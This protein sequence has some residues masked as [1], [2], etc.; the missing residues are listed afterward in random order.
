MQSDIQIVVA[1]Q[2]KGLTDDPNFDIS[3]WPSVDEGALVPEMAECFSKRKRAVILYLEG[4]SD[5]L[6]FEETGIGRKQ[7]YRL[8][9]ERCIQTHPDGRVYGWRGL[10]KH[11]RINAPHRK[12]KITVNNWG[13]G[14]VGALKSTMENFPELRVKFEKRVLSAASETTLSEV[15]RPRKAN[16]KWLIDKFREEGLEV[17]GEWPFNTARLGYGSIRKYIDSILMGNP[18]LAAKAIG[19][20]DLVK[21]LAASD[22]TNRPNLIAFD[23]VEVDAHKLDGRFCVMIPQLDGDYEPKIVHRLWVVVILEVVSRAVLGYQFSMGKEVNKE[24]VLKAIKSALTKWSPR[25]VTF[26]ECSYH[27]GAGFPSS[28]NVR[29]LGACW[30]EFSVDGALANTCNSVADQIA[31]VV[32]AK[33]LDPDNSYSVRRTKDDRPFIETFFRTV[34]KNGLQRLNNTTGGKPSD[35]NGY[36]PVKIALTSQFQIEYAEDLIDTLIANYNVAPHGMLGSRSPLAY[37]DFITSNNKVPIR[38]ADPGEIQNLLNTRKLVTLKG[39]FSTGRRPYVNFFGATYSADW[40]DNQQQLVGQKL[41][42]NNF[43]EDDARLIRISN[44]D[45]VILGILHAHPPWHQSPH[46]LRV[47]RAINSLISKKLIHFSANT[48][49]IAELCTYVESQSNKK[50]PIHPAYLE[51]RAIFQRQA[52]SIPSQFDSGQF[53]ISDEIKNEHIPT[54]KSLD[55]QKKIFTPKVQDALPSRRKAIQK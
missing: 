39:G 47:R 55:T 38:Y 42:A 52:Q 16:W 21:K 51:L 23:R 4:A 30:N 5:K 8:I 12:K 3:S 7:T 20:K 15:R 18:Y 6:I 49:V 25:K 9:R 19:G 22:G 10:I 48:D 50:F 40:L 14:A 34:G 44:R 24:D 2:I 53:N 32:K 43:L 11:L 45:G 33:I 26:S 41:W 27:P 36:D 1:R 17:K 31:R 46:S 28:H 29:F 37:L 13:G 54:S 35:K